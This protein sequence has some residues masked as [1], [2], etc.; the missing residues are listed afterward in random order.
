MYMSLVDAKVKECKSFDS[1]AQELG[2][3]VFAHLIDSLLGVG[4]DDQEVEE[5][6][7]DAFDSDALD[8]FL[9]SYVAEC[10]DIQFYLLR[11]LMYCS[12]FFFFLFGFVWL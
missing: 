5:D 10:R 7:E 9:S 4:W 11:N 1:A 6:S 3:G 2:S 8:Y 12:P